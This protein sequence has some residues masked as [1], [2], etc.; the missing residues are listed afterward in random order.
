MVGLS[1][2]GFILGGTK[3]LLPQGTAAQAIAVGETVDVMELRARLFAIALGIIVLLFVVNLVRT[4]KLKEEFALLWLLTAV[5]LVLAPLLIDYLDR[6]AHVL[7][8]EY[9]PA[10]IF[11]LA[12]ISV[13]LI[14]FQFSMRISHFSEQ[15]KV[16]TQEIALLRAR[17]E[18]LERSPDAATTPRLSGAER[19]LGVP[20]VPDVPDGTDN[21]ALGEEEMDVH[22]DND[23]QAQ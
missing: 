7:G 6:I 4:R 13:L 23:T 21:P 15:I 11:V 1:G 18:V 12:I 16:L 3:Y 9:P 2:T 19:P 22:S 5:V 14:L 20:D 17:L 10:F 8:I